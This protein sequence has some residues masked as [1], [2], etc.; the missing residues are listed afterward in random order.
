MMIIIQ[1]IQQLLVQVKNELKEKGQVKHEL[2][3]KVL[4]LLLFVLK[5]L[6]ELLQN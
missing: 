4:E 1:V 3:V 6:I 5:H 2:M